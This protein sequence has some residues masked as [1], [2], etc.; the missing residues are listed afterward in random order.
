M[1][2]RE[3]G[4][5]EFR[6]L[7]VSGREWENEVLKY[8]LQFWEA[9]K[10]KG[11]DEA[12]DAKRTCKI[13]RK[14]DWG[15]TFTTWHSSFWDYPCALSSATPRKVVKLLSH[16]STPTVGLNQAPA[17]PFWDKGR[18][19]SQKMHSN[20][21]TDVAQWGPYWDTRALLNSRESLIFKALQMQHKGA[22]LSK[23]PASIPQMAF[24][25]NSQLT[26]PHVFMITLEL[27]MSISTRTLSWNWIRHHWTPHGHVHFCVPQ[28]I[29]PTPWSQ[30]GHDEGITCL[31]IELRTLSRV[32]YEQIGSLFT[33]SILLSSWTHNSTTT[34]KLPWGLV[35]TWNVSG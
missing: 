28:T 7:G 25:A 30:H 22:L 8:R 1:F 34:A 18:A 16:T 14:P 2:S 5:R 3:E 19:A 13:D 20:G 21:P 29:T 9:Q 26:H 10:C 27:M 17:F 12:I 33:N 6:G 31:C 32:V 24:E 11:K 15:A 4:T 23:D 35:W